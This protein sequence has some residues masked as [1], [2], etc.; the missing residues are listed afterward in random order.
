MEDKISFHNVSEIRDEL[1]N[2]HELVSKYVQS[3]SDLYVHTLLVWGLLNR[4]YEFTDTAIWAI[5]SKRPQTSA[6]ML[7]G[8]IETLGF[9]YYTLDQILSASDSKTKLERINN[10]YFGSRKPD[11]QYKSVNILTCIDKATRMFPDLRT[12]YNALSEIVHPN[13]TSFAYSGKADPDGVEGRVLFGIPF[14]DFK[15]DDER[16]VTNQVGEC[17]HHIIRL[18]SSIMTALTPSQ[19]KHN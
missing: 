7:R 6:H 11:T 17:C 4:T 10:L 14:Y 12:S 18:C 2:I 16:N 15:A 5:E 13:G 19:K 9:T 3:G 1:K 8:L